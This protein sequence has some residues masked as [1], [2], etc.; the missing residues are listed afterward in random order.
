MKVRCI[1]LDW[2][3][4]HALEP[5]TEP[6]DAEYY[7]C[8]G[9]FV[10]ERGYGTRV[11]SQMFTIDGQDG[12][13]MLEVRR[14]PMSSGESGIL[15]INS[16][17][18]RLCN[19][20]C[21]F[22][23][24]A[25]LLA[26][27]LTEHGYT[28]IRVARVDVCNDFIKF[29]RG[30]DPAAFVRR[31]F[32]HVYAKI[33]QGNIRAHGSD[34]WSGQDWNSLSWGSPSSDVSTKMYDKTKELYDEKAHAFRKPYIREAWLRCHMIDDVHSCT[35]DGQPVR[36]WRVEFSVRSPRKHW[37]RI[38]LNGKAKNYQS[39]RNYLD[40]WQGRDQL[41]VMFASLARHYFRF[42]YYEAGQRKDRCRDKVLFDFAD[43]QTTYKLGDAA[44]PIGDGRSFVRP[45]DSLMAKLRQYRETHNT[46]DVREAVDC[47][48]RYMQD[49]C[50]RADLANPFAREELEALRH[51]MAIR[52]RHPKL[53]VQV[54]M[55]EVR[56]FLRINDNTAT[57]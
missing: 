50:Y 24:P 45:L 53:H 23:N 30:D 19:R 57:F 41:L 5:L 37:F 22:D 11:Y 28:D 35:K 18:I 39:I 32:R 8:R 20:T 15:A 6:R 3:E 13:P 17:H 46:N 10:H 33:N 4:V 38:E 47:L 21:Y 55:D 29:D 44:R 48:L 40:T 49:D 25:G 34:T 14:A 12:L 1:N 7:R 36:V 51:I 9:Y 54:V 27:F 16:T 42:K 56:R 31:F 2:L 26:D 52:S 43:V